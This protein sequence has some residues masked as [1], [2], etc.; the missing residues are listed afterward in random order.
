MFYKDLDS[1]VKHDWS[2]NHPTQIKQTLQNDGLIILENIKNKQD[3]L[4]QV[5]HLGEIVYHFD[6]MADGLTHIVN[7]AQTNKK[8]AAL[9]NHLGLTQGALIPHTDRSGMETPPSLLAFWIES[10]SHNGGSSLFVDSHLV[11]EELSVINPE[12]T[13]I[14]T[15]P[16]SVVFKSEKGLFESSIFEVDEQNLY[17][18]FRF[19]KMVYFSTEVSQVMPDL[20]K[21]IEKCTIRR[22]LGAGSGYIL[23]NRRWLHGRTHFFGDRSAYRLLMK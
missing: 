13:Q 12:A 7:Q 23:N 16:K 21:M 18:R 20:L 11:F 2:F 22:K 9:S 1:E 15:R 3:F 14:L 5:S 10:Q 4:A 8:D 6:S 17:V 19:D